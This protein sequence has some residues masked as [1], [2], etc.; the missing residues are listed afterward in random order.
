[1]GEL[2]E[3]NLSFDTQIGLGQW[4]L[5]TISAE[6]LTE[7][8]QAKALEK[9]KV[10]IGL[11]DAAQKLW[12]KIDSYSFLLVLLFVIDKLVH[13]K[14]TRTL[15]CRITDLDWYVGFDLLWA[16][17]P[18][19]IEVLREWE[20]APLV[21][22]KEGSPLTLRK[23]VDHLGSDFGSYPSKR[24]Q[25]HSYLRFFLPV[26]DVSEPA[27]AKPLTL[28]AESRPEF[29]DFDLFE[30]IEQ[31]EAV[32]NRL[33]TELTYT[34]FDM[35]TTGL[36]PSEGDEILSIGAVRIVNGRLL[37]DER[38]EQLVDPLRT[39][40]WESVQIHGIHPEMLAGQPTIDKILPEFYQYVE[41]T[42]LVAHNAAFD[43]RFLEM[44]EQQTAVKFN[45]PVLDTLL[46]SAV[47]HPTHENHDLEAIARRLG[48]RIL[49]RHTAMGDALATGEMFLKQL[50]LLAQRGIHTLKDALAAS[51]KTYY[52][53]M[54][55]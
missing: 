44:K 26:A 48:V 16:G 55:F 21:F 20:K 6:D 11:Q 50:P 1:M 12:V 33:L 13:L 14:Q 4:P 42:I 30:R 2:L 10:N 38:F 34:V 27:E 7:L 51:R 8:L 22:E 23:M 9:L 49:G 15:T 52:A 46:L 3:S 32:E 5:T 24:Q 19:K 45:N 43:M 31:I 29:Y 28:L 54:K 36:N 47:V 40:P 25:D 53:R 41:D 37:R 39:I 17:S 18:I 35:E